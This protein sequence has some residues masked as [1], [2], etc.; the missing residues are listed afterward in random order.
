MLFVQLQRVVFDK[1]TRKA[2]KLLN[3]LSFDKTIYLDRFMYEN[4]GAK[5]DWD[6]IPKYV[7]RIEQLKEG[8]QKYLAF[9][10]DKLD[11][12]KALRSSIDFIRTQ[13]KDEATLVDVYDEG[14]AVMCD[15]RGISVIQD[16][17]ATAKAL[18]Q[19]L[20][21]V[22]QQVA[23][24]EKKLAD[25]TAALARAETMKRY[26]YDLHTILMHSGGVNSGHYYSFVFDAGKKVWR[27]YND[28]EVAEVQE[29]DV[30]REAIG[31]CKHPATAYFLVYVAQ[32]MGLPAD[33]DFALSASRLVRVG[34]REI[35][36]YYTTLLPAEL[37]REVCED[38][39]R[40]DIE[41]IE[42]MSGS[43]CST[44][45]ERYNENHAIIME[46]NKTKGNELRSFAAYLESLQ[47][48]L[49]RYVL[50]DTIISDLNEGGLNLELLDETD[51]LYKALNETFMKQ[52]PLPPASL[53]LQPAEKAA[54]IALEAGYKKASRRQ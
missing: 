13:G 4:K 43:M 41:I 18:E 54:L 36:K 50:L 34:S 26:R 32:E 23:M 7:K 15:P 29:K 24:M 12:R 38:N 14:T 11:L 33:R 16:E 20:A 35:I 2:K 3:P 45:L 49:Y 40:L 30:F 27:K 28:E 22:E 48:P 8:L 10:K 42:R 1:A 17:E 19:S 9:G 37:K 21:A 44:A 51:A 25:Y 6:E 31:E 5:I 53:R 52:C 47:N 46:K 39:L